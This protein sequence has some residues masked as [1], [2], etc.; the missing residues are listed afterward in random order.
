MIKGISRPVFLV[1]HDKGEGTFNFLKALPHQL[2]N[3]VVLIAHPEHR[4]HDHLQYSVYEDRR[5][6]MAI[7]CDERML[8]DIAHGDK[9]TVVS[10]GNTVSLNIKRKI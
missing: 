9:I 1:S 2:R 7:H 8:A 6:E 10:N 5:L 3:G 4:E